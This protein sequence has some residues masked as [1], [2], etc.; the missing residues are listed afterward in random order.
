MSSWFEKSFGDDY[1]V[2]YRHRNWQQAAQEVAT[3]AR[4]L[5]LQPAA[6]LLDIGCGMGRHALALANLG[7]AVT[8]IDLSTTLLTEATKNDVHQQLTLV[9]GDMRSLP[10]AS[11]SFQATVNLFTSFGYFAD[12]EDN[13]KVLHEIRRVLTQD[14][15][16]LIDFLNGSYVRSNLVPR[17]ERIDEQTQVRIV[18]QRHIEQQWVVKSIEVTSLQHPNEAR[19]YEERV[20]LLPLSWFER[21]FAQVGLQ[22]TAVYGDYD[23]Q[24]YDEQSSPRM[25]MVGKVVE[26]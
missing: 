1:M 5:Q 26:K 4:W 12:D 19:T 20:R 11:H 25:I 18:E 8:G 10:F 22:L 13:Y 6:T 9:Q 24:T 14:G 16:F 3:M 21:Q 23:G 2:V 7:Y 17:S 15:K